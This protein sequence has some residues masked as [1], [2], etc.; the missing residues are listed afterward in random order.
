MKEEEKEEEE[1][2]EEWIMEREK[3][4]NHND[5]RGVWEGR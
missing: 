5:G 3:R 2:G 4:E 1:R